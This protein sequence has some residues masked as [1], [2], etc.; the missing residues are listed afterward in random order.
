VLRVIIRD[1]KT[2][3]RKYYPTNGDTQAYL[4]SAGKQSKLRSQTNTVMITAQRSRADGQQPDDW[5]DK[6]ILAR[7]PSAG[8]IMQTSEVAV[9]YQDR[10]DTES[11]EYEM[12]YVRPV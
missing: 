4:N 7:R 5:S 11:V 6:S 9:E 12:E 3:A 8:K 10:K 2:T 1:V